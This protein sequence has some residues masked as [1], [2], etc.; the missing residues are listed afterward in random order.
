M[1]TET[2]RG[3]RLRV[4]K[5]REWGT[6]DVTVNGIFAFVGGVGSD[7]SKAMQA[8][9]ATVDFIDREPV[10][11]DRWGAEWYAP[12]TFTLC[13]VGHPV[14]IDGECQHSTCIRRNP[15]S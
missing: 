8:L 10:N 9:R 3:R 15:G 1:L 14:A 7:Q 5:G 4:R 2:Y 12:G 13:E 11:G 6:V